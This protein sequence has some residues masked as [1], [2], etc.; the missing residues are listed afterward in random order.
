MRV[1][2]GGLPLII[3]GF[4][5]MVVSMPGRSEETIAHNVPYRALLELPVSKAEASF[6]YGD[7]PL[8]VIYQYG[9]L[10]DTQTV[11]V[12][13][14]GGCWLNAYDI[15]HSKGWMTYLATAGL[16]VFGVEYRRTGDEGGGW[17]GSK[18][19]IIAALNTLHDRFT[20]TGYPQN[21]VVAGHS[22]GGHLAL[23]AGEAATL[24]ID[25]IIGL[26]AI[27][28][29]TRYAQ[30][31]NSCQQATSA[32]MGGEPAQIPAA[33][34]EAQPVIRKWEGKVVLM[35]GTADAIVPVS[36]ASLSRSK[37]VLVDDAGHF[38]WLY[39]GSVAFDEFYKQVKL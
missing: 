19:D 21:V 8:Q 24:R 33:Y 28:D 23:L 36:H 4:L 34:A 2:N 20:A 38:D 18:N 14:H 32:F 7:D 22:A 11:V 9:A 16:T 1:I 37:Q 30:G 6:H 25:K 3:L 5:L 27:T 29:I 31:T 39:P 13:I 26:A 12:F 35:Q 10:S 15:A 17:P